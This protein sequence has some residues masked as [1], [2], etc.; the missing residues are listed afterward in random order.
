MKALG[1]I[2]G[3]LIVIAIVVIGAG[4]FL[5]P[6][7]ASQ[8][9]TVSIA[10]PA[11]NVYA[12]LAS[13]PA[14]EKVGEIHQVRH[15]RVVP[16][17]PLEVSRQQ[18]ADGIAALLDQARVGVAARQLGLGTVWVDVE[19]AGLPA[20]SSIVPMLTIPSVAELVRE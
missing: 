17:Q 8:S 2:L 7:S 1:K 13:T 19:N 20:G 3:T 15:G 11:A 10:K 6:K 16:G 12:L 18:I 9:Q 4:F 5:L 14:G